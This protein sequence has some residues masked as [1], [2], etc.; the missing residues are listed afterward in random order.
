MS[1]DIKSQERFKEKAKLIRNFL[2]E[3]CNSDISHSHSLELVAQILG[4][5]DWNTAAADLKQK[6][7][8]ASKDNPITT[9]GELKKALQP[10]DDS[11]LVE[12]ECE[13]KMKDGD[14]VTY[15]LQEFSFFIKKSED[16]AAVIKL[17]L[18]NEDI[19]TIEADGSMWGHS[20]P[21]YEE[22]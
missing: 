2:K 3:K 17:K 4:Y 22:D 21:V 19:N 1:Q 18:E 14:A 10:F 13:L 16:N 6:S 5:K 15:I 9:V 11:T 20:Y 7:V 8:P 12:S